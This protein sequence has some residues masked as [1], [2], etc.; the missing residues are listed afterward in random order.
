MRQELKA[1]YDEE[2]DILYLA[3]EGEENEFVEVQPGV[4]LE[5]DEGHQIIGIEILQASKILK[6]VITPLQKAAKSKS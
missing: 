4:N 5:L 2:E 3:R 6:E 1:F